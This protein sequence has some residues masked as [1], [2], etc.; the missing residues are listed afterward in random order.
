MSPID[1]DIG[2]ERAPVTSTWDRCS[3]S[4]PGFLLVE[5]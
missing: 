5:R 2:D 3:F 4:I 1:G